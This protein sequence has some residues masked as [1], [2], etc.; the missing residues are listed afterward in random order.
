MQFCNRSVLRMIVPSNKSASPATLYL[1]LPNN[2]FGLQCRFCRRCRSENDAG[3]RAAS[4]TWPIRL[5]NVRHFMIQ[6]YSKRLLFVKAKLLWIHN[7][8]EITY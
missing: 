8:F 7:G 1:M 6:D 4:R 5:G 3:C 2:R